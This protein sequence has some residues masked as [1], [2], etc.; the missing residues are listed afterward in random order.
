MKSSLK[1]GDKLRLGTIRL[2]IAAIKQ[3]EIDEKI[4]LP[5]EVILALLE[6]LAK[7]RKESMTIYLEA[8]RNEL[9]EQEQLE[10]AVIKAYLPEPLSDD[11]VLTIVEAVIVE[12]QA[13]SMKDMG[14]VMALVKTKLQGRADMAEVSKVIKNKLAG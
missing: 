11:A 5:D 4:E 8:G 2:I 10:L 3:R 9:A 12:T 13:A 7:Q 14:K 1:A 6:K